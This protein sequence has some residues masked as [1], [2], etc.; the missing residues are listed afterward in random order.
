[1][2]V[3][4]ALVA[5]HSARAF[6]SKNVDQSLIEKI[7]KFARF[8]PSGVNAQPWNVAVVSGN[9]KKVL[10]QKLMAEFDHSGKGEL[11]YQYYPTNWIEPFKSRRIAC[12]KLM[13]ETLGIKRE[14]KI[15]QIEQWKANYRAFDAPVVMYFFLDKNMQTG[16]FLDY[17]MFIQSIMLMATQEGLAT[18]PQAALAEYPEIIIQHLNKNNDTQLICGL[19]LGYEDCEHKVNQY[20]TDKI[21]LE[22][23][24]E[25]FE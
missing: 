8:A 10:D 6:L 14:D 15:G 20:R 21:E 18:C 7:L 1:M 3:E 9:S 17:G 24:C 19:A 13:Y 25:F 12:G 4:Q 2:N 11:T 23:F 16:S 22:Q 5:R